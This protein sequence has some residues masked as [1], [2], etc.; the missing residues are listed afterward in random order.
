MYNYETIIGIEVHAQ[1]NT[2]RKIFSPSLNDSSSAPNT[3]VHPIDLG[4]PG[5]LPRFNEEVLQKAIMVANA[6]DMD[7]TKKM[8]WDRK[9]YFYHDNPKGYQ[10]TQ[11]KTPIGRNGVIT[12]DN[13]KEIGVDFMHMEEDTAK[14]LHR[15]DATLLDFNRCG[16]PLVE[17]VSMPD[18][19][20][21]A[22]AREYVEKLR[23][24]LVYLGVSDGKLEEGSLRVDVNVS[25][26]PYGQPHFNPKVEIK[27]LNSFSNV[28]MAIEIEAKNQT[29]AY[30]T[31]QPVVQATKRFMET[32]KTVETMRV[33][34]GVVD[35]RYFPEP[36]LPYIEIDDTYINNVLVDS[37]KL[38]A[39]IKAELEGFGFNNKDI[40]NLMTN[41]DMV[42]YFFQMTDSGLDPKQSL[43]YLLV[44]I[45]DV[46]N[47]SGKSFTEL[48]IT[49]EN[50]LDINELVTSGK[51]STNHV[52]KILPMLCEEAQDAK[53]LVSKLGIEQITDPEV[54]G[55]MVD[56]VLDANE[57]SIIDFHGGKDRAVGFLIGQIIKASKGQANPSLVNKI[58]MQKLNERK[59]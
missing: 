30:N 56:D 22:E 59:C 31:N 17:I 50:F 18:M 45:K 15:A 54:I 40:A 11:Q 49:I 58:L 9:N 21:A 39:Q 37:A 53:E 2:K 26:R 25:V 6:F 46:L 42:K 33:K 23:E 13:G 38:P 29:L 5:A 36:D 48:A 52:K 12:L 27:N 20:S 16:V 51:I 7:I 4:M 28:A 47:K 19:R 55:K 44:N 1:L 3:N 34:E 8:H 43:N 24:I 14:S 35:Y 10:I 32:S 41:V 57:Q